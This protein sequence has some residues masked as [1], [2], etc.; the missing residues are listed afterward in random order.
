VNHSIDSL[1]DLA[2]EFRKT[3]LKTAN[4]A[5]NGHCG[6]SL[7]EID[8][9]TALYFNVMQ[10]DPSR[11]DWADRDRF[12][13]SKGHASPGFYTAL[14]GRGYFDPDVLKTFDELD[15][16]LQAHPDMHKC[17]GVDYSTG[18]LGQG[19]SVGIGIALGGA[20]KGKN[21]KTFVLVG[22]GECQEGQIWEALMFAGSKKVK[23][24]I[25]IVDYNKV[26]LSSRMQDNVDIYPLKVKMNAFNLR[27]FETPGHD[28]QS[29]VETLNQAK[30]ASETG[31]VVVIA[32]TVK[33]KG[34]SFM[35]NN[36]EW[37]GKAP[38]DSQLEAA[39]AELE[40]EG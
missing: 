32:D 14:S 29:L 16:T 7:S 36:Y 1:K 10:V 15:S 39:L 23:N 24:L 26:Q 21:F 13:L 4:H 5:K 9:L 33:G 20:M 19:I 8:I 38:D 12:I 40:G 27:V 22:D 11:P 17:P 35:E 31:P 30:M 28:M 25:I 18:S 6:G 3:I 2:R 34:V 37:H